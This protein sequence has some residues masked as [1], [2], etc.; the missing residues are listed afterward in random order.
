MKDFFAATMVLIKFG[1][2]VHLSIKLL[3]RLKEID[4]WCLDKLVMSVC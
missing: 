1:F 4:D 3:S 2:E